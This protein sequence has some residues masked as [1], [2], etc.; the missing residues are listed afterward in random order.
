M[1]PGGDTR[2]SR[3]GGTCPSPLCVWS[4]SRW[5]SL[6][7]CSW[8]LCL[9]HCPP[10]QRL[11]A[12]QEGFTPT[13]RHLAP[14]HLGRATAILGTNTCSLEKIGAPE[15][16]GYSVSLELVTGAQTSQPLSDRAARHPTA[17]ALRSTTGRPV[18]LPAW[19]GALQHPRGTQ[20]L[21][22]WPELSL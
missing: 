21:G 5:D 14:S 20:G 10:G 9:G 22:L 12:A 11:L 7:A 6:H 4:A 18:C 2:H 1:Q 19:A 17:P 13:A 15:D 16:G 8:W 3:K